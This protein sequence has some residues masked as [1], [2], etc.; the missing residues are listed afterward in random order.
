M[1]KPLLIAWIG[2]QVGW[3]RALGDLQGGTNSVGQFDGVSDVA[4]ACQLCFSVG[5]GLE[6]G[7]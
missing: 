7:Q 2:L 5:E 3:D 6:K 4:P 1:E